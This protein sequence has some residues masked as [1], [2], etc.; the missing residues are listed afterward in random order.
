MRLLWMVLPL[1]GLALALNPQGQRLISQSQSLAAAARAAKQAPH[2]T[3]GNWQR[4]IAVAQEATLADPAAPETWRNLA[5][6]Y[7]ETR[8]WSEAEKA[9]K[10]LVER[11]TPS[12]QDR[13]DMAEV[14]RQLAYAAYN[15]KD[16]E[17]AIIQFKQAL[18]QNPQDALSLEWLGRVYLEK[19]NPKLALEFLQTLS[20]LRPNGPNPNLRLAQLGAAHGL[21]A[22]RLF[23]QGITDYQANNLPQAL[24]DFQEAA[25]LAPGFAEAWYWMGRMAF[26]LRDFA[27]AESAYLQVL[28]LEPQ[29]KEAQ[30]WL[31]QAKRLKGGP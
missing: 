3:I 24:I 23:M 25:A 8:W 27:L 2:P 9:W 10:K 21:A 31:A 7:T 16:P 22:A 1:L 15:R 4:A 6:L 20:T 17:E 14:H 19:S 13:L 28:A 29:N 12:A 26:E 11:G 18:A 5:Q 30:H